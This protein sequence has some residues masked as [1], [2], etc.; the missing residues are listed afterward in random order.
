MNNLD[1]QITFMLYPICSSSGDLQN[2]T[3]PRHY[4]HLHCKAKIW[5]KPKYWHLAFKQTDLVRQAY[6]FK[7]F[8]YISKKLRFWQIHGHTRNII[9][10]HFSLSHS[11]HWRAN[12]ACISS[13]DLRAL[14]TSNRTQFVLRKS[15]YLH[16]RFNFF[17][18]K[19]HNIRWSKN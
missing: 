18:H 7:F 19:Y 6:V 12:K 16:I 4:E 10:R 8:S 11:V 5:I 3:K 9:T 15:K 17:F 14:F 13:W 2:Y 1:W